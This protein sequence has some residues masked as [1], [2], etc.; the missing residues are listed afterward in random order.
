MGWFS[1]CTYIAEGQGKELDGVFLIEFYLNEAKV[2]SQILSTDI[3][4]GGRYFSWETGHTTDTTENFMEENEME[5]TKNYQEISVDLL[6]P[7]RQHPFDLYEGQ[8]FADMVESIR[9]NGVLSPIIVRP[10]TDDSAQPDD[11]K[12][13][14]LSGHNRVAAAKEAEFETVPAVIR[15][16]LSDED[17]MFIVTETNLIQRSFADMKHTER[18]ACIAVHYEAMKKKAGYRSDLLEEVE[19]G[20]LSPV[21]TRLASKDKVAEQY[22]LSK[23]TIMRYLRVSKLSAELKKRLDS[24]NIGMRVAVSLSYLSDKEQKIVEKLLAKNTRISIGQ[25]ETLRKESVENPLTKEDMLRILNP[26]AK[27]A[28]VKPFKINRDLMSEFFGG[29]ESEEDIEKIIAEALRAYMNK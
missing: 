28:K 6:V 1:D 22:G 13:E 21:G 17:A 7:F 5:N 11:G 23:N 27:P 8:R 4:D 29:D 12:F 19:D 2:S 18:A 16:G 25:A 24:E 3:F 20:T 10:I 14:I 9:E 26:E 15:E